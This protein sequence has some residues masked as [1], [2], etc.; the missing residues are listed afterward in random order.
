M[1]ED[2]VAA[3]SAKRRNV[4]TDSIAVSRNM[5]GSELWKQKQLYHNEIASTALQ[6]Y[7]TTSFSLHKICMIHILG[8]HKWN[9]A[10]Q[11]VS[12]FNIVYHKLIWSNLQY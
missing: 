12:L 11:T 9:F 5:Y 6:N 2:S 7:K 3:T 10:L 1:A 4:A 8:L